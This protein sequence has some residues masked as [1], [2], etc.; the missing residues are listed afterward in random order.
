LRVYQPT[1][2]PQTINVTISP[3]IFNS[4]MLVTALEDPIG[5]TTTW[6]PNSMSFT[7]TAQYALS[8]VLLI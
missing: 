8:S 4:S 2:N 7:Y 5:G 3:G 6:A 1:N